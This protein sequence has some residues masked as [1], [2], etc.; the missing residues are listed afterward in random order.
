MHEYVVLW[1]KLR[2]AKVAAPG[3]NDR[4]PDGHYDPGGPEGR[5]SCQLALALVCEGKRA[6]GAK[7]ARL[8]F[9]ETLDSPDAA[10]LAPSPNRQRVG[11]SVMLRPRI[12]QGLRRTTGDGQRSDF[13]NS[14]PESA[15][16]FDQP[17]LPKTTRGWLTT[18]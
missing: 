15:T 1:L 3:K 10:F 9:S 16:P 5:F 4:R 7:P 8:L 14:G 17:E 2:T 11:L 6:Y 12:D 13:M 18:T